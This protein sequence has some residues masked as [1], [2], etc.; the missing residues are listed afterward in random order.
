MSSLK[1]LIIPRIIKKN[2]HIRVKSLDS[3]SQIE[4]T[5]PSYL[6]INIDDLLDD[7][8]ELAFHDFNFLSISQFVD[9]DQWDIGEQDNFIRYVSNELILPVVLSRT[10]G[11]TEEVRI[12]D[13]TFVINLIG[14]PERSWLRKVVRFGMTNNPNILL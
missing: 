1:K 5:D 8:I 7:V 2:W 10:Y 13:N 11:T 12:S 4:V 14:L 6:W 3:F 9:K